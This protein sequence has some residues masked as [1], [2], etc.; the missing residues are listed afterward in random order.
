[1]D[2]SIICRRSTFQ[3][4]VYLGLSWKQLPVLPVHYVNLPT[5]FP[6][7][8]SLSTIHGGQHLGFH[9]EDTLDRSSPDQDFRFPSLLSFLM[10]PP[11]ESA[12]QFILISSSWL[13]LGQDVK[14]VVFPPQPPECVGCRLLP[15]CPT[16]A[17]V[18]ATGSIDGNLSLR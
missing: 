4:C 16:F 12:I 1:M 14:L 6:V 3:S 18:L 10:S 15:R 5:L 8:A 9:Y 17:Q 13:L 2:Y 7:L 11:E